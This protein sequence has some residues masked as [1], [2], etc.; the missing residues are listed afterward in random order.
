MAFQEAQLAYYQLNEVADHVLGGFCG[1][2]FTL[3]LVTCQ[4]QTHAVTKECCV[5]VKLLMW[6]DPSACWEVALMRLRSRCVARDEAD[7]GR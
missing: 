1:Q 4:R 6:T 3:A 2:S 7:R 5:E